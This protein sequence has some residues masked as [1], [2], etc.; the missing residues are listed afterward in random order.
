[1]FR[2][3]A[4][5]ASWYNRHLDPYRAHLSYDD[6]LGRHR[7]AAVEGAVIKLSNKYD[8]SKKKTQLLQQ[9]TFLFNF[10][11]IATNFFPA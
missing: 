2:L 7:L 6:I 5:I 11:K 9:W 4:G 8:Y 1:M 10:T 3:P